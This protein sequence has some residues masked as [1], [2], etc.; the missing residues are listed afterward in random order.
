MKRNSFLNI[1]SLLTIILA[2]CHEADTLLVP[3]HQTT[4]ELN[5]TAEHISIPVLSDIPYANVRFKER[6]I[7]LEHTF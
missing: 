4:E 6:K 2:G 1:L 5:A 7:V 3:I